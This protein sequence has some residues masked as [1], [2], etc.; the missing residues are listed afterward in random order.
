[1]ATSPLRGP[2]R[3]L[4]SAPASP[5]VD[6]CHSCDLVGG[7]TTRCPPKHLSRQHHCDPLHTQ[8]LG[9]DCGF[10]FLHRSSALVISPAVP[11]LRYSSLAFAASYIHS[12]VREAVPSPSSATL[13]LGFFLWAAL[14]P[15][16][17]RFDPDPAAHSSNAVS[18]I[19]EAILTGCAL[20]LIRTKSPGFLY[21]ASDVHC[22]VE[23]HLPISSPPT[24]SVSPQPFS[25]SL[26]STRRG[27][28]SHRD[29]HHRSS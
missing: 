19:H 14:L 3:T 26:S 28:K 27:E 20:F 10:S 4:M 16:W 6:A 7:S 1:M 5:L 11:L 12:R 18:Q 2:V 23:L 24:G 22:C 17:W 9:L 21:L 8:K 25:T 15:C 29:F 13:Y